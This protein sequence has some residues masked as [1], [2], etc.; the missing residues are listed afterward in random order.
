MVVRDQTSVTKSLCMEAIH[1]P[2]QWRHL[3]KIR[4]SVNRAE[5]GVAAEKVQVNGFSLIDLERDGG[6][7]LF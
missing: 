7:G 1:Q 3:T 4:A 5:D 6:N 2:G